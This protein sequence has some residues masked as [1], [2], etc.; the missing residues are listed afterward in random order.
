MLPGHLGGGNDLGA[1]APDVA[2]R[3]L[4]C[5]KRLN[6]NRKCKEKGPWV[7]GSL[8]PSASSPSDL[9]SSKKVAR[10]GGVVVVMSM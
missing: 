8:L 4:P 9:R 10:P 1:R 3:L 7:D 6:V 2:T 5:D